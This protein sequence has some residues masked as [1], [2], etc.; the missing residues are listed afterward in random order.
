MIWKF[1]TSLDSHF[2]IYAMVLMSLLGLSLLL[3]QLKGKSKFLSTYLPDAG[4]TVFVGVATGLVIEV[5]KC[6]YPDEDDN[7]DDISPAPAPNIFSEDNENDDEDDSNTGVFSFNPIF[8]LVIQL[9]PIIFTSGFNIDIDQFVLNFR[10]I[11]MFAFLGTMTSTV[12]VAG[13][14]YYVVTYSIATCV[15]MSLAELAAFGALISAT[16][17]VSTLAVFE[18]K[19]VGERAKRASFL[20][21]SD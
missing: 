5:Y 15:T 9:P 21:A 4:V 1:A 8:F 13:L 10:P 3:T 12:I 19:K 6:Y 20:S 17:P 14:L 2:S 7:T 11:A 18:K 16:D